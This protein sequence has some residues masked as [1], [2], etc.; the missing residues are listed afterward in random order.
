MF[1]GPGGSMSNTQT[2]GE[3]FHIKIEVN[4]GQA[5]Q[6]GARSLRMPNPRYGF[7]ITSIRWVLANPPNAL[8]NG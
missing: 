3:E 6:L 7:I 2:I 1:T 4:C 5:S 8:L